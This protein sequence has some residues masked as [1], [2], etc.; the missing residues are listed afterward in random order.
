[1]PLFKPLSKSFLRLFTR[2]TRAVDKKIPSSVSGYLSQ[3]VEKIS[4]RAFYSSKIFRLV[5]PTVI[6]SHSGA[7]CKSKSVKM[8]IKRG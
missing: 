6:A 3:G 1:M 8:E 2:W 5:A 7:A 4:K